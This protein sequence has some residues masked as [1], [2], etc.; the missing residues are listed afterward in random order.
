MYWT[1]IGRSF[2]SSSPGWRWTAWEFLIAKA[3]FIRDKHGNEG[4]QEAGIPGT[5]TIAVGVPPPAVLISMPLPRDLDRDPRR[6]HH[7][8]TWVVT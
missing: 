4:P 2:P 1:V 3:G 5:S 8:G 6:L 7:V